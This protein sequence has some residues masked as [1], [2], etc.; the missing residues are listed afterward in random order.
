LNPR[1]P[2]PADLKSGRRCSAPYGRRLLWP[3]SGTPARRH[4]TLWFIKNNRGSIIFRVFSNHQALLFEKAL[5]CQNN[6]FYSVKTSIRTALHAYE[7][8]LILCPNMVNYLYTTADTQSVQR[9]HV[10]DPCVKSCNI[11]KT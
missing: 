3:G 8:K 10:N 11:L 2:S 4:I 5:F 9:S 6:Q 7:G 1:R